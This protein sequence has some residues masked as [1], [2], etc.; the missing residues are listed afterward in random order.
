MQAR[1]L[2]VTEVA[3]RLFISRSYAY[4]LVKQGDI[5]AVRIGHVLRVLPQELERYILERAM[6]DETVVKPLDPQV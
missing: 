6:R 3:N 5:R 2:K 4:Q 1:L